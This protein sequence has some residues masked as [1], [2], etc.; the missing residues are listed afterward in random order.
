MFM[1]CVWRDGRRHRDKEKRGKMRK[2]MRDVKSEDYLS[3]IIKV[4]TFLKTT[5]HDLMLS[6]TWKH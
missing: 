6:K 3:C 2:I 4:G 5:F 1:C